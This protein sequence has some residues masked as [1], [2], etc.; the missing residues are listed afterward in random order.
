MECINQYANMCIYQYA[1]HV[2][3]LMICL[4]HEPSAITMYL[5]QIPIVVLIK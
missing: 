2:H 5:K 1:N 3:P 4:H